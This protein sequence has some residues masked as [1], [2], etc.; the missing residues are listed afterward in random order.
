MADKQKL[1]RMLI[2]LRVYMSNYLLIDVYNTCTAIVI[3]YIHLLAIFRKHNCLLSFFKSTN[4]Y[5][6]IFNG[7][8]VLL[9]TVFTILPV[10][11]D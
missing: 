7:K 9:S 8:T 3:A 5:P 4:K 10:K 2:A 11:A 6:V 1:S